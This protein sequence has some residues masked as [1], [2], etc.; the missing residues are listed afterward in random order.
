VKS[1]IIRRKVTS[2]L[3]FACSG[4]AKEPLRRGSSREQDQQIDPKEDHDGIEISDGFRSRSGYAG[5]SSL[6]ARS[7]FIVFGTGS[8]KAALPGRSAA[9]NRR[10]PEK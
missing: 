2:I 5:F 8:S 4:L 10:S 9:Q 3:P 1:W 6:I 7:F